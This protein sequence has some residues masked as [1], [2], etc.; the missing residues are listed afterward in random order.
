MDSEQRPV[1]VLRTYL[2][3]GSPSD[4]RPAW[5]AVSD[6]IIQPITS[7][8][9]SFYRYLYAEV[10]REYH[11]VDR[12]VWSD[13]ALREYLDDPNLRLRVLLVGGAPAGYYEL[14][15]EQD[16]S[17]QIA[18]FGL[19]PDFIGR[20][21]GKHLLSVAIEEAWSLQPT[22]VWL[23]TCSLDSVAALPNYLA[24]GFMPYQEETYTAYLPAEPHH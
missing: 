24:R 11:W 9:N 16:G 22:H 1:S 21:L 13:Q 3:M 2:R 7:C 12:L 5:S 4:F 18:Y 20:G 10:G 6:S 15:Q 23:H 17:I 14:M 8:P 19:L